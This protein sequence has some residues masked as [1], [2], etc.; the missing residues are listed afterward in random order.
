MQLSAFIEANMERILVEWD[1]F[2]RSLPV[3]GAPLDDE[4]LR[5][6]ARQMLEAIALD[7]QEEESARERL[8]K[9]RGKAPGEADP[10]TP[11]AAHGTL[12]HTSGYTLLQLTAEFRA[13][14]AT[15]LRLWLARERTPEEP[16]FTEVIRFNETIDQALA[17]SVITYSS[18]VN[19]TRDTFL[20]MLGH[21]LRTPLAAMTMAGE[22]LA[23]PGTPPEVL[24]TV[25]AQVMRSAA[26]MAT[27]VSDLLEYARTQMGGAVPLVLQYADITQMCGWALDDARAAHPE[28]S[29]EWQAQGD[30]RC[31]HDSSRLQQVLAN[32]LN[33]A[34]EFSEPGTPVRLV[35]QGEADA[36][37]LQV[38]N[39]GAVIPPE[40]Q[41]A[42][43][44][45]LVQLAREARVGQRPSTSIGLGLFIAR[46]IT[47]AH[48]G[49]IGVES[50]D[51]TGTIFSVRLLRGEAPAPAGA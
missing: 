11:A 45:P 29:F 39:I 7:L 31:A 40:S 18:R 34:A 51:D 15:V 9:S 41:Q 14:R 38:C 8:L 13:L 27:M 24:A 16:N 3:A 19:R 42:I 36:V 28:G 50:G 46:E 37:V 21:D 1:A 25:G 48:G 35:A 6:H 2:A 44:D 5:D 22:L 30:L 4:T 20:A 43:F 10:E 23:R 47:Q 32:L 49:T 33:N 17:Q 12:R 26:S